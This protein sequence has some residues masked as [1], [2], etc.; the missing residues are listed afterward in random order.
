MMGWFLLVPITDVGI[1]AYYFSGLRHSQVMV[2]FRLSRRGKITFPHAEGLA[3]ELDLARVKCFPNE[4]VG[5]HGQADTGD[6]EEIVS[7]SA[8]GL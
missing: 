7:H 4:S 5:R 6:I 1:Y 2:R 3:Q 8:G